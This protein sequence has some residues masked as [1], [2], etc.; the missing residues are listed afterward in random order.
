MAKTWVM[1]RI[2]VE[3]HQALQEMAA[4]W[5]EAFQEGQY[6]SAPG[7]PGDGVISLDAVIEELLAREYDHRDRRRAAARRK[8]RKLKEGQGQS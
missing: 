7:R 3:T 1:V 6:N 5:L 8:A 4:R 2:G